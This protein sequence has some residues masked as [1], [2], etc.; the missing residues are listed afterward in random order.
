MALST[1]VSTTPRGIDE[2]HHI[3]RPYP[4]LSSASAHLFRAALTA[5]Y[6]PICAGEDPG[7]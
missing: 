4:A 5:L 2:S 1:S 6:V 7:L 3:S